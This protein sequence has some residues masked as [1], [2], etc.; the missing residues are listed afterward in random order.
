M[1]HHTAL[2]LMNEAYGIAVHSATARGR[3][4]DLLHAIRA[5]R[6]RSEARREETLR[7]LTLAHDEAIKPF[8]AFERACKGHETALQ[9]KMLAWDRVR[10]RRPRR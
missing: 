1:T 4:A 2:T 8:D 10:R 3:A 5:I 7:L 9:S 6:E